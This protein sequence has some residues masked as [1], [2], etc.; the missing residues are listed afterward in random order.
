MRKPLKLAGPARSASQWP[1]ENT[2]ERKTTD[3]TKRIGQLP[4]SPQKREMTTTTTIELRAAEKAGA[5]RETKVKVCKTSDMAPAS[6]LS[7]M[8]TG[9][10]IQKDQTS[11]GAA[12]VNNTKDNLPN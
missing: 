10:T 11:S 4:G 5:I 8:R 3:S 2:L 7:S 12:P 1:A 6:R 9:T